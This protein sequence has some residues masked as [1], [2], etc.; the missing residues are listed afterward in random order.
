M[1]RAG[2]R[3]SDPGQR[4]RYRL[5]GARPR[6]RSRV[7]APSPGA[8]RAF[9][10]RGPRPVPA[11]AIAAGPALSP[12]GQVIYE[13]HVGTF[14]AEGTWRSAAARLAE[15]A[16]LGITL[17]EMMPVAEFPGA[18]GWGYDGVSPWAPYHHYGQPDDLRAF[19]DRAH[20]LQLGVILDVVYNHL[21]PDGNYLFHCF[22]KLFSARHQTDWGQALN[23]DG[24]GSEPLRHFFIDNAAYWIREFHF[25]G[26]RLDATQNIYDESERHLLAEIGAAVRAAA[27]PRQVVLVAENE[28][29]DT[30]LI[31][32]LG[33]AAGSGSGPRD[34]SVKDS[35]QAGYGL[36]A[37]WNDDYHHSATVALTGRHE[38]YY[39]D[40][41][42]TP[43]ELISALK[44]GTLYQGQLYG[45]QKQG[46]GT[47]ALDL[48]PACFVVFLENHDQVAN[49]VLGRRGHL[50]TSPSLWR[51]LTAL[52]LLSPG[53]PLLLQ[54]QG[55]SASAPFLFFAD[56][57]GELRAQG[58]QGPR[59]VPGAVSLRGAARVQARPRPIP[60]R[61]S[62]FSEE[63][64]ASSIGASASATPR[65]SRCTETC[66]GCSGGDGAARGQR[67]HAA[68]TARCCRL[69][70]SCSA[71][72][73][74]ISRWAQAP[75]GIGWC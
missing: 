37:L 29:Q 9:G 30:R 23:F 38:A 19:I 15:L 14:T 46:R 72:S 33:E 10:A 58:A 50:D 71:I 67:R 57:Q 61:R 2:G 62:T 66:C 6:A 65:A 70:P 27:A 1:G 44:W 75:W 17:I 41:R 7:P 20:Q 16:E 4:Y 21:G 54:G 73:I 60:A 12:A 45:W 11:G 48:S 25:D 68:L 5:D 35:T 31:R 34:P 36:D 55:F 64:A 8:A 42:G 56:H 69:W 43:Q 53:A 74:A 26:L 49:T 28:P 24:P 32:P 39:A 22:P 51:T 59:R 3:R 40:Y 13:L 63:A 47:P 52:T 18:F